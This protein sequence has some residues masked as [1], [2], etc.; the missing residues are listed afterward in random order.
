MR[1]FLNRHWIAGALFVGLAFLALAPLITATWI[2]P[3]ALIYLHTP[4]Y[5]LHQVEEHT[6]DRFRTF[7][8]QRVF[9]GVEA[10]TTNAVLWI[11]LPGVWGINLAALYGGAVV[12]PGWGLAAPY[13]MVVNAVGHIGIIARYPGYNPGLVTALVVFLPLGLYSLFAIPGSLVQHAV[14]LAISLVIHAQIILAV[15]RRVMAARSVLAQ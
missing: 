7:V 10:L 4:G 12:G 1:S 3:L 11:N 15:R 5:M 9:G 14:G 13:L 6:D 2:W 8:N